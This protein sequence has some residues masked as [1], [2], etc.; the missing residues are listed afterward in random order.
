LKTDPRID[1]IRQEGER[2]WFVYLAPGWAINPYDRE[3]DRQHCFGAASRQEIRQTMRRV[4]SCEC[5]DCA[6]Q[7]ISAALDELFAE[8]KGG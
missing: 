7:M 3:R 5:R 2:E 1:E 6:A 8:I 4:G